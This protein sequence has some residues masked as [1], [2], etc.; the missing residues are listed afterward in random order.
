EGAAR[1]LSGWC[2]TGRRLPNWSLRCMTHTMQDGSTLRTVSERFVAAQLTSAQCSHHS[3]ANPD[4]TFDPAGGPMSA[5]VYSTRVE[6]SD[7]I[8]QG[9]ARSV[10]VETQATTLKEEEKCVHSQQPA[11]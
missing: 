2:S 10:C 11:Q 4:P 1:R 8:F 5:P 6:I 3:C 9:Q 7:G